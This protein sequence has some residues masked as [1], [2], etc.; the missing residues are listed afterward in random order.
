MARPS[1]R[2]RD[3]LRA[4]LSLLLLAWVAPLA[5][6]KEPLVLRGQV[7]C[8]GC[9]SEADRTKTVYGTEGDHECAVRCANGGLPAA[10]AV[11]REGKFTLHRLAPVPALAGDRR[12][13]LTGRPVEVRGTLEQDGKGELLRA[14]AVTEV[15]WESLGFPT[16]P[17]P[18]RNAAAG[19]S[20]A[21]GDLV[22]ADLDG[23]P[24]KLASLRGRVVVLNFWATWCLPCREEM[25]IFSKLQQ[26]FAA[27]GV[28]VIGASAD[29]PESLRQ[30]GRF[31]ER[32]AIHFPVWTGATT[33]AMSAFGLPPALPGTV[34]LDR[35]GNVIARFPGVV[36]EKALAEAIEKALAAGMQRENVRAALRPSRVPS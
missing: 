16:G 5:S 36:T 11:Y 18:A 19:P 15:A 17:P 33:E 4:S 9:W 30:V 1:L 28:Q 31:A 10:L 2:V 27:R 3:V 22:L 14:D 20:V 21:P 29:P 12:F 13:A 7:V 24:Q 6:A 32:L 34:V 26:Q 35:E 25:P 8:S 23:F